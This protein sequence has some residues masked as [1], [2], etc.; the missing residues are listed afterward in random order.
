MRNNIIK[1]IILK[2][3]ENTF[4]S[5]GKDTDILLTEIKTLLG[6]ITLMRIIYERNI[7]THFSTDSLHYTPFFKIMTCY[8]FHLLQKFLYLR[9]NANY[10]YDPNDGKRNC[11][12]QACPFNNMK[13]SHKLV[14]IINH[15]NESL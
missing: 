2:K 8:R 4:L 15:I 11:C 5:S 3:A 10:S 6:L 14:S 7:L 9:G 1:R 12:H 13:L